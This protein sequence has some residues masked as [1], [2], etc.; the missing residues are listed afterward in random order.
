M[1]RTH[2]RCYFFERAV[3]K[4]APLRLSSP[5]RET[6]AQEAPGAIPPALGV[7]TVLADKNVQPLGLSGG[8]IFNV[9]V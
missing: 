3:G 5:Q 7:E 4:S 1:E 6:L 9:T 2:V 8:M